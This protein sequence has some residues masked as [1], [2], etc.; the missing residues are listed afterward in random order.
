MSRSAIVNRRL[1]IFAQ[2]LTTAPQA[3]PLKTVEC[4]GII[5]VVG[6][7]PAVNILLEGL[8][9]LEARGYDSAGISTI[10]SR[11]ELVTTKFASSG[12]TSNAIQ[13]LEEK[14]SA[15]NGNVIGTVLDFHFLFAVFNLD[16]RYCSH[17]LGYPRWCN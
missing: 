10:D 15:H 1:A 16:V 7:D 12:S 2:H 13:L 5:A 4:C 6:S 8:K 14:S 3:N 9:I 11:G 17:T